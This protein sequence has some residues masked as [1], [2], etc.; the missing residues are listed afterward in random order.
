MIKRLVTTRWSARYEGIHEVK[1]GFQGVIQA[2][3]SLTSASK[4]LQTRGDA[5]INLLSNEDFSFMSHLFY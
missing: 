5:Q 4:S 1:T 3:Y 2:V